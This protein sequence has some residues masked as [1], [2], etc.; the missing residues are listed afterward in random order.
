MFLL[1]IVAE[2]H[3]H[4]LSH[5]R[6]HVSAE[7]YG[8]HSKPE[9]YPFEESKLQEK[10]LKKDNSVGAVRLTNLDIDVIVDIDDQYAE[11]LEHCIHIVKGCM[12]T[13]SLMEGINVT[14]NIQ[15]QQS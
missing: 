9:T 14:H 3:Q 8:K 11:A 12:I 1:K 15:R 4:F 13:N 7:H 2:M 5:Q 6:S 10:A